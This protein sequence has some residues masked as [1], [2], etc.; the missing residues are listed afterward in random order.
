MNRLMMLAMQVAVALLGTAAPF[1]MAQNWPTKAVRM[2]GVFPLGG[3]IDQVARVLSQQLT[4]QLGQQFIVDNKSGASGSIGT[5]E[6]AR[7]APDGYT[8]AVVF[9][10][11]AVNLS[12]MPNLPFN[13]TR[14]L[15]PVMLIGT[16][17]MAIVSHASQP[18]KDFGDVIAAARSKPGSIAIGS[19][20]GRDG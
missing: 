15:A 7:A 12:F 9:D 1:A 13:T 11:H 4:T 6:V 18:Y 2:V 17:P 3:S 5:A 10:T 14:D 16:S 8:F 19:V 20:Q